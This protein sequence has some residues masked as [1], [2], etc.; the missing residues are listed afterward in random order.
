MS[1]DMGLEKP[2]KDRGS[3]TAINTRNF[4]IIM[5]TSDAAFYR[6]TNLSPYQGSSQ[7]PDNHESVF[8]PHNLVFLRMLYKSAG[9]QPRLIQGIRRRDG[10]GEGQDTIVSIRY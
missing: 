4:S 9:D 7:T 8:H 10:I 1:P 2:S 5:K 3:R 6:H